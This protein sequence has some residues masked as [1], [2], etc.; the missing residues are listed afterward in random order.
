MK[1][2]DIKPI[3]S[4]QKPPYEPYVIVILTEVDMGLLP[5]ELL[6]EGGWRPSGVGDLWVR[7]NPPKPQMNLPAN[8]HVAHEKHLSSRN[9]QVSWEGATG[10][11]HDRMSFDAKFSPMEKAKMVARV[12]LGLPDTFVLERIDGEDYRRTL[13]E[14]E[15]ALPAECAYLRSENRALQPSRRP[16]E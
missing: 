1:L 6:N 14:S 10:K 4:A 5:E 8:A 3:D 7:V 9:K 2:R 11:R 16:Q 13:F 15:D 12:A